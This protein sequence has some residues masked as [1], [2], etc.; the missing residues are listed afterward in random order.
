MALIIK[1]QNINKGTSRKIDYDLHPDEPGLDVNKTIE[2]GSDKKSE[3]GLQVHETSASDN[4]YEH[5]DGKIN[6]RNEIYIPE[7]HVL[8]E[9]ER[10]VNEKIHDY[11]IIRQEA[12]EQSKEEGF[13]SGME[14][15][16]L[17][18]EKVKDDLIRLINS[19]NRAFEQNVKDNS[20]ILQ[21]LVFIAVNR[22]LG[23]KLSD[24]M[25]RIECIK[26]VI[27]SIATTKP[28]TLRVSKSDYELFRDEEDLQELVNTNRIISDGRVE[29]GGCIIETDKGTFDGRLEVQLSRL[30]EAIGT[31]ANE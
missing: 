4:E 10:R 17:E 21:D 27:D 28:F 22:I 31:S 5:F 29:S 18:N 9:V 6:Y 30:K 13:T 8:E 19:I 24:M 1:H 14:L 2:Y 20:E 11:E 26:T 25:C 12:Y 7:S 15:A 16:K 23:E 3:F